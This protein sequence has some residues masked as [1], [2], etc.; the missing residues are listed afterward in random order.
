MM[1]PQLGWQDGV[2]A[3][4]LALVPPVAM[5]APLALAPLS[6]GVALAVVARDGRAAAGALGSWP[7]LA[8]ALLLLWAGLS[9]I[10]APDPA[11]ALLT[12]ARSAGCAAAGLVVIAAARRRSPDIAL[13]ALGLAVAAGLLLAA[14]VA[15]RLLI[16]ADSRFALAAVHL[17][18]HMDR[19]ATVAALLVWPVATA[20]W[21]QDRRRHAGLLVALVVLACGLSHD[22]AAKVGLAVGGIVLPLAL[23][24][25]RRLPALLSAM[26]V[27]S[28][29][30]APLAARLPAP[31][32]TV[33][34]HWLM[35][36]AHHRLTIWRFVGQTVAEAPVFGHGVE[37]SRELGQHRHVILTDDAGATRD[38]ELLPLHP[39]NAA[40]QIWLELGAVGVALAALFFVGL[41]N[42]LA[43]VDLAVLG[44][45]WLIG[46]VSYGI[47]QSWWQSALWLAGAVAV[48]A[49]R[50]DAQTIDAAPPK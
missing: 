50:R 37:A 5:V 2:V 28:L 43:G 7:V 48:T 29:V 39:H 38:E 3:A 49:G 14:A 35:P 34:W 33:H 47:W 16:L 26:M 23:R 19:G 25:P 1:R 13:L 46:A 12:V 21:R 45:A 4:A 17:V 36:T 30:A 22:A 24:W 11:F 40:L 31:E 8:L 15:E 20:L 6:A 44:G 9:A 42:G 41:V 18:Y 27:A 32:R 10:W